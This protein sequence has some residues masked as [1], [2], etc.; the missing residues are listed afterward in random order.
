MGTQTS[1]L[2]KVAARWP[3]GRAFTLVELLLV[4][5]LITLLVGITLPAFQGVK[6][7]AKAGATKALIHSLS[8]GLDMFKSESRLGRQYPPSR[9][10]TGGN[11]D[12][13]RGDP[14]SSG[15]GNDYVVYGAQT[16]VWALAGAD[17]LGTPG[18]HGPRNDPGNL[19]GNDG[20]YGLYCTNNSG[21]PIYPRYGPFIDTG[22]TK[23]KT[24]ADLGFP[25]PPDQQDIRPV[26]P[27]SLTTSTCPCCTLHQI[28]ISQIFGCIQRMI[29]MGSCAVIGFQHSRISRIPSLTKPSFV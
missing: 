21:K 16:L 20:G 26:P 1:T 28:R 4:I 6:D 24:P 12:G 29:M 17:L 9:W 15:G 18:F 11:P 8:T 19:N 3:R 27:S 10:N 14:Y 2:I 13:S 7:A 22:K 23:I 5:A 25:V